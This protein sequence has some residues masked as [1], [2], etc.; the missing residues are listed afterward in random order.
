MDSQGQTSLIDS[1]KIV[2][3][4]ARLQYLKKQ[5]SH[6][7]TSK[8]I[9]AL[10]FDGGSSNRITHHILD[11]LQSRN[12]KCTMFL[13]GNFIR[14]YPEETKRIV[15][16]GHEVGNHS[17]SHPHLTLLEIDRSSDSRNYVNR[18]YIK[19]QLLKT[20]S[21]FYQTTKQK[22]APLW[23][24]PF[25]EQNRD[26]ITWAAEAGY[27]H[28]NWSAK[29]DSW[30]WVADT[31]SALYRTADEIYVHFMRLEEKSGLNGRI[32][33]MHLGSERQE[34]FPYASLG[35]II[36]E[37]KSRG[38]EFLKI[39]ELLSPRTGKSKVAGK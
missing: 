27:K 5:V 22:M 4:S 37:L 1:F 29:S 33:L 6:V 3:S 34:D 31:S 7:F 11:T 26:I 19:T 16:D 8:K 36:D 18:D 9:L 28:I 14:L 21:M 38:Y 2:F 17:Y 30:D 12:V 15:A 32:L 20:D 35:R 10:T 25:G 39:S 23:R 13:T 24:A